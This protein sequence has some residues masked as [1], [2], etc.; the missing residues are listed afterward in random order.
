LATKKGKAIFHPLFSVV[1]SGIRDPIDK[2]PDPSRIS[3]T[4][5]PLLPLEAEKKDLARGKEV[6]VTTIFRD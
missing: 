2:N 1:G 4:G 6:D 3:N 5:P